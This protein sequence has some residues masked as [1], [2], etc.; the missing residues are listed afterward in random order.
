MLL[1]RDVLHKWQFRYLVQAAFLMFLMLFINP[2]YPNGWDTECWRTWATCIKEHGLGK[3]YEC[4]TDYLPLYHY[5]LWLFGSFQSG[6]AELISNLSYLKLYTYAFD[7]IS[8]FYIINWL[9]RLGL[10]EEKALNRVV[11][12]VLNAAILYN[13]LVWGQVDSIFTAFVFISVFFT[14]RKKVVPAIL[15]FILA[16]N[17]KLQAIVFF[18]VIGLFLLP[19][20][21]HSFSLKKLI[22]WIA[23]PALL[24]F[25]I[26]LPFLKAGTFPILWKIVFDSV[27]KY[28]VISMNA[29]NLWHF[30][31]N[32][33]LMII[34]D[35]RLWLGLTL[36]KWGLILFFAFSFSVLSPLLLRLIKAL[37]EKQKVRFTPEIMWLSMALIP[38]AFFFFNTQ[39]HERYSHP[40]LIFL[41]VYGLYKKDPLP[42]V[43]A[44]VAYLLNLEDVLRMLKFQNHGIF[45]F[46]RK[47][48]AALYVLTIAIAFHRYWRELQ[49]QDDIVFASE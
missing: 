6:T 45:L 22:V 7:L 34:P 11:F 3:V 1:F 23:A 20:I 4:G 27:D 44:C 26:V 49:T 43:L 33:N 28:P 39:M 9:I 24:Q 38:L 17:M 21:I 30:L 47:F 13:T 19:E 8:G 41:I 32:G 46:S 12:Y 37:K 5:I 48:I 10:P 25:L 40:A 18:P 31:I 15:F 16:L 14:W 2:E 42:A 29:Y 35:D 36:K